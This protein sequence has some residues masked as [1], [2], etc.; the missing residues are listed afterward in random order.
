MMS[1]LV[2]LAGDD[3]GVGGDFAGGAE[4]YRLGLV[5]LVELWGDVEAV[6]PVHY[7]GLAG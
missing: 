6:L 2:Q 1:L 3:D 5:G 4:R 7:G